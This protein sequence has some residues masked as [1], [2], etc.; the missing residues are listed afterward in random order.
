MRAR[1]A[2]GGEPRAADRARPVTGAFRGKVEELVDRSHRKI[3]AD[4]A[5]ERLVAMGYLGSARSTRRAVEQA[6]HRYRQKH[7][8][9]TRPWIAEPGLWLQWDYGE[10][11]EAAGERRHCSAR[12]LRGR[13]SGWYC[14]CGTARCRAL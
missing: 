6:K 9:R 13:A 1:D 10:G 5:H 11:P 3:R 4:K 14:R 2:A 12:G 7:G 8:R